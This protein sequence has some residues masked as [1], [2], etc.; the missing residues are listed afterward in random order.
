MF[1]RGA[2]PAN[3]AAGTPCGPTASSIGHTSGSARTQPRRGMAHRRRSKAPQARRLRRPLRPSTH[4]HPN[5]VVGNPDASRSFA[6]HASDCCAPH[7]PGD[8]AG[9]PDSVGQPSAEPGAA[10]PARSRRRSKSGRG[11]NTCRS[12]PAPDSGHTGTAGPPLPPDRPREGMDGIRSGWNTAPACVLGTVWGTASNR[13]WRFRS[14]P[15][16]PSGR[17]SFAPLCAPRRPCGAG[18]PVDMWTTQG[19]CPH[20]SQAQQQ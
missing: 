15:C 13:T 8:R 11:R 14:A 18:E 3:G 20:T 2:G 19:R 6:G 16:L 7:G 17:S 10:L 12:A 1:G 5:A 4:Q 9:L